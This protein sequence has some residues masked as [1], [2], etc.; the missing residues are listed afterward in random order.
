M[1]V[2]LLENTKKNS[3][4][5]VDDEAPNIAVLNRLLGSDYTIY[6]AKDGQTALEM[7]KKH[8]PDIILLDIIM[9]EMNGYTMISHL[10]EQ[11]ETKDIPVIFITGLNSSEDEEKGLGLDAADYICKPFTNSIVKLR[12]RNQ[13]KIVNAMRTIERLSNTDS[14]TGIANR[15]KFNERLHLEWSRAARE[16]MDLSLVIADVDLFK[17]YNDTHGHIQGDAALQS[18]ARVMAKGIKRGVDMIARWGGEEFAILLPQTDIEG[19]LTVAEHIRANVA[20]ERIPCEGGEHSVTLSFGVS[21]IKPSAGT[22]IDEFIVS[23]DKA[24][25]MAKEQGRNRVCAYPAG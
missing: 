19:A 4:L 14:L 17:R 12:V 21:S 5:I 6:A 3:I 18:V 23:A 8:L 22:S 16:N 9:P 13:I 24:L 11:K 10:K 15:R 7:A 1:D 20:N 25:Y 2:T